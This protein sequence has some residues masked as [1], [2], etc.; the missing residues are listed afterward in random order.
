MAGLFR[1]A[2]K[3]P[4]PLGTAIRTR[5]SGKYTFGLALSAGL[6]GLLYG[7]DTVS[8]SGAIEF[9]RARYGLST[10]MEGLVVSSIMLGAVIGAATAGFLSDRFGRKRI[11]IIGGAFF[12]VAAVW[13]A[14]TI[15][16]IAL[17]VARVAG[18]YG[19]GLTAALAVTYITESAPANIRGLLAFSYQL[20]AVCGI[21]L[22]N[23]INYIIASHGSNDWDI[24]TGWRWMLGLGAIPAATFL[25]A[26]RRAP[27]SPRF[28]IQIGRTDEGFAVLEHILGTERARLRTDD[29][30]ASVKLETEMSH[31]FHDL[32]RP[33]LRRA[34]VIGIFLAVFN[35]F[36]GMNAI[37]YYGPVMF[38]D[39]GFAGDTQFLAAASVGGVELVATV[40]GMYL[41]DTFGRKRLMEIGTGMMCVFALCISGSYFMGNSLLT[42]IFVMAFTISFAFS[43]GPIPWIVIPELFPTYLRGRATG[44]CVMCLLFANWIIA[45][46]TPMMIDGLGGGISFAIFAVLDLICLFGIVA[47]V[48]ETMGR[49]LEEIEH[50]WQPKTDLAYAKYALSTADANIRH[51]EATLRRIEN[52]RQ[53]AL[54]IMDAAE[55]ARAA[56]QQKIFAIE[57][58]KRVEAE[59]LEAQ[60]AAE[61]A[62]KA[63]ANMAAE[64]DTAATVS[65]VTTD[66]NVPSLM[67]RTRGAVLV[68]KSSSRRHDGEYTDG[69]ANG[70]ADGSVDGSVTDSADGAMLDGAAAEAAASA[71]V[72]AL[73]DSLP[74]DPFTLANRPTTRSGADDTDSVDAADAVDSAN[75]ANRNRKQTNAVQ[76]AHMASI[77][78]AHSADMPRGVLLPS[79]D[80]DSY[81]EHSFAET[82]D[83]REAQAIN[84]ALDSLDTLIRG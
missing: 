25:L 10:L 13:S 21:F 59:R 65:E 12:L 11:L 24:A 27:E 54:G 14:L 1:T 57:T 16:P 74:D 43:M 2:S 72:A 42:L 31:E 5:G 47:L 67:R 75:D 84:A 60:R 79:A 69:S 46:F 70:P 50:L 15:G 33:G 78:H 8:I 41:I 18:G 48:P 19:I 38:S 63:A 76:P 40:V 20:L 29:I 73:A 4:N 32:F 77:G 44:L 9:L 39:L 17:I 68:G 30:Q 58:A 6:A 51:A 61:E 23:V 53:Q 56:A 49:T 7:Y 28:L 3:Q 62:A 22:T 26:M 81:S 64:E 34:L 83:D 52:E 71:A 82:D 36:I 80:E 45:Q 37:S 55:R 35:Q 66:E